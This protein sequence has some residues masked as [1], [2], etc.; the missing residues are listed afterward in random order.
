MCHKGG[1]AKL[2]S[3]IQ[4]PDEGVFLRNPSPGHC[5]IG[6]GVESV[7]QSSVLDGQVLESD[8]IP[9][10]NTAVWIGNVL[11]KFPISAGA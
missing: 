7:T 1:G 6:E 10:E 9:R 3:V 8:F 4:N 2:G 11:V 5:V